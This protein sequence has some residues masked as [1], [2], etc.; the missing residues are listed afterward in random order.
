MARP[1]PFLS[2]LRQAVHPPPR[3]ENT[4]TGAVLAGRVLA[5]FD[6]AA[7]R[8][9]LLKHDAMPE[10][11]ALVIAP[12]N[13]IHT[14]FMRFAIDVA[15]VDRHGKVLAVRHNLVPWRIAVSWRAYAVIEMAAGTLQRSGTGRGDLLGLRRA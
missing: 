10:D 9:G 12:S 14:F 7:R 8:T 2:L 11:A 4:R 6:S 5:A 3:L 15:F 1:A 13:G